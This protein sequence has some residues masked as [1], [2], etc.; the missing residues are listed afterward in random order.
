MSELP[1][2]DIPPQDIPPQNYAQGWAEAD[3]R[4][5][6]PLVGD[7]REILTSFLDFHRE[8][9]ALK[10]AG[11]SADRLS[12]RGLP[13]SGLSLHG[14]LRHLTGVE[15][16][17]FRIQFAGADVPMLYYTDED[18]DQ[19][20]ERLD[21]DPDAAFALWREECERSRAIVA[22]AASLDETGVHRAT[23][24]PVSLRRILVHLIAEYARHNGHA[25][26][27]R[28]RIDGATGY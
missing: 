9:F 16:W 10:C 3:D 26:L 18:P 17:W 11:V 24:G 25:D 15:R 12:E 8:T 13:P 23:G 2:Q 6:P 5:T 19:D 20:F 1:P 28:E 14:L 4:R 7:E 21:G 27:L 22:A